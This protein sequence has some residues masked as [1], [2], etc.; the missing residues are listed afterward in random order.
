MTE[1]WLCQDIGDNELGLI[2]GNSV[3]KDRHNFSAD[4]CGG[5]VLIVIKLYAMCNGAQRGAIVIE[6]DTR[7]EIIKRDKNRRD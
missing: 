5:G 1:T 2:G 3:R 7:I 6:K 4:L